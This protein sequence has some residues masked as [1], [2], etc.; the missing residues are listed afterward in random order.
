MHYK[1]P[2][3]G[4]LQIGHSQLFH[5]MEG[6]MLTRVWGRKFQSRSSGMPLT[7]CESAAQEKVV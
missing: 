2:K 7:C 1:L 5:N 4:Y 6:R 3:K